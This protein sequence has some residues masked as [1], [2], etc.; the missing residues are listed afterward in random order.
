MVAKLE[1]VRTGKV[2]P[3][4]KESL[5]LCA[6]NSHECE[7]VALLFV[8]ALKIKKVSSGEDN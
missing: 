7:E 5:V 2:S 6:R 3:K 1:E 4:Q 8:L